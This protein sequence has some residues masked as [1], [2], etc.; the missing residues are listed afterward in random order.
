MQYLNKPS[1]HRAQLREAAQTADDPPS[2]KNTPYSLGNTA[3]PETKPRETKTRGR[4]EWQQVNAATCRLVDLDA[5]HVAVEASHGQWGGY[6]QPKALA[7]AFDV[8]VLGHDWRIRVRQRGNR[9][10]AFGCTLD[11]ASA[12]Q[13]AQRA[14][15]NPIEPKPAK[16]STPLNLLGGERR[17][18][19]AP[20]LDPPTYS[21]VR[22]LE[23][24][25]RP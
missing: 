23:L 9:W 21:Y 13:I 11:L 17:G 10:R 5:R 7:Y 8:G 16:F 6:H 20:M 15:E 2:A 4:L 19:Y 24:E 1:G 18:A 3:A 25:E 12:K 22:D 14:V